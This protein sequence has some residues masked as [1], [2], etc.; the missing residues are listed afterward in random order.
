MGT[1]ERSMSARDTVMV[2]DQ[3]A[4]GPKGVLLQSTVAIRV[5]MAPGALRNGGNSATSE[6][7]WLGVQATEIAGGKFFC[8]RRLSEFSLVST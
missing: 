7:R 6:F 3:L 2:F 4:R 8:I 1:R 5:P